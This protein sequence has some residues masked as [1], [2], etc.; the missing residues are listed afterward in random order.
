MIDIQPFVSEIVKF[1]ALKEVTFLTSGGPVTG[2][3]FGRECI[4]DSP[5]ITAFRR[6]CIDIE[7]GQFI[8]DALV[9]KDAT[10]AGVN[11]PYFIVLL[12]D[13]IGFSIR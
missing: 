10:V 5:T 12:K 8:V 4:S 11:E 6:A 13:V 7:G 1:G 3:L 9:L 2:T